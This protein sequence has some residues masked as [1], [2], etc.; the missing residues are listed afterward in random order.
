MSSR[1]P[2]SPKAQNLYGCVYTSQVRFGSYPQVARWM[3]GGA[4]AGVAR[5]RFLDWLCPW[6]G[7]PTR[8]RVG[9]GH[10]PGPLLLGIRK[11]EFSVPGFVRGRFMYVGMTWSSRKASTLST[12]T[13]RFSEL[14]AQRWF[15]PNGASRLSRTVCS[16]IVWELWHPRAHL[17][18]LDTRGCGTRRGVQPHCMWWNGG[19][20]SARAD[21]LVTWMTPERQ[22]ATGSEAAR[23]GGACWTQTES[24]GGDR[25]ATSMTTQNM[26]LFWLLPQTSHCYDISHM[27]F[28]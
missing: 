13:R 7:L 18:G 9:L 1:G 11:G 2:F 19:K 17:H 21:L 28:S 8:I 5:Q 6:G 10:S 23:A 3:V 26:L 14:G 4:N 12:G 15:A 22:D 24:V 20:L 25:G 27:T 16:A